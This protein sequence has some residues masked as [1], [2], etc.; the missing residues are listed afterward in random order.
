[1]AADVYRGDRLGLVSRRI[2]VRSSL[3]LVP[4]PLTPFGTPEV[5]VAVKI[6]FLPCR[7][8]GKTRLFTPGWGSSGEFRPHQTWPASAHCRIFGWADLRE[9]RVAGSC[10]NKG[11]NIRKSQR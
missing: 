1:V 9:D 6:A 7:K 11:G 2:K 5:T 10:A 8:A 3:P 4:Q